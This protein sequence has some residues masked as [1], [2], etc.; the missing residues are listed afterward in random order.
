MWEAE[1]ACHS[2]AQ[3]DFKNCRD[4]HQ[5]NRTSEPTFKQCHRT[6]AYGREAWQMEVLPDIYDLKMFTQAVIPSPK[7]QS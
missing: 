6:L 3:H 4:T 7:V 5:Y 1:T 2:K